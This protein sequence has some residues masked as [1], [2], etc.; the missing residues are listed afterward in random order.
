MPGRRSTGMLAATDAGGVLVA[1]RTEPGREAT[2]EI[3]HETIVEARDVDKRYDTGSLQVHA[4]RGVTFSVPRGEM[5]A[6][7]GPSGSGKTTLLNCLSGLDAIDGGEVLIEGVVARQHVRRRRAR[8]TALGAW[9]S[10]S[11]STT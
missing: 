3:A 4:L 5:V 7:M 9:A 11:S 1:V 6:I 8:T 2:R 10:S